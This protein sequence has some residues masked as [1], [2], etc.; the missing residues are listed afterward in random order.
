MISRDLIDE[1]FL[2]SENE[3]ARKEKEREKQ[4]NNLTPEALAIAAQVTNEMPYSEVL[5]LYLE[6]S[7]ANNNV[8]LANFPRSREGGFLDELTK[9]LT[10]T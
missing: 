4:A 8:D 5:E 1:T 10:N 2:K 9:Y 6:A 3:N 7:K